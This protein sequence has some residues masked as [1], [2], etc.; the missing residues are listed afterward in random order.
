[1]HRREILGGAE[2]GIG[3]IFSRRVFAESGLAEPSLAATVT[4]GGKRFEYQSRAGQD[5]GDFKGEHFVQSCVRVVRPDT[6]LT[7]Y[8]R[9]DRTSNR[10]EVVFELGRLWG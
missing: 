4:I 6:P 7:V 5:L 8:F 1:M 10:I 3:S 9:P 2:A